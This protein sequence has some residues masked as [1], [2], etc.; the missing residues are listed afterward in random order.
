MDRLDP[1]LLY[2]LRDPLDVQV[3]LGRLRRAQ[4]VGLVGEPDV[5]RSLVSLRVDGYGSYTELPTR[6]D[7]AYGHL[8]A[9]RDQ[10]R[11]EAHN[12]SFQAGSRFSRKAPKPS[13][14]SSPVRSCAMRRAIISV[15]SPGSASR[16]SRKRAFVAAKAPG[17]PARR[18]LTFSRTATSRPPSAATSWTSPISRAF[19]ASK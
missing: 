18:L 6:P 4:K 16:S 13:W 12:S 10:Q 17:P 9:I 1:R 19:S 5:H 11:T 15:L 7:D 2:D 14:P 3:A 8:A